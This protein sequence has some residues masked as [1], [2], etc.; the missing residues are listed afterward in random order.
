MFTN[1]VMFCQ[2]RPR[3]K[4]F[5]LLQASR[6]FSEQMKI[7]SVLSVSVCTGLWTSA[8]FAQAPADTNAATTVD[9]PAVV[10]SSKK[11]SPRAKK[12]PR[13][14]KVSAPTAAPSAASTATPQNAGDSTTKIE[15]ATGPVNGIVATR[16]ATGTKTDTPLIETSQSVSVISA[17]RMKQQGAVSVTQALGYTAGVTGAVYGVDTRFDWL[18]IRGFDAYQPGFFVDGMIARNNNTW[19]VW[20]V[21][22]YGTERI[23]VLKGPPSVLYGQANAGGM[24]NVVSKRPLEEPLNETEL[25]IGSHG[26]VEGLFDF[27]G[28][29]TN[30]G[31]VLYRLTG[32]V[33]DT[34]T[35][36]DYTDQKRVYIAPAITWRPTTST[37]LTLL[38]Q[39]LKEDDVPN[40]GFLPA[41]GV[42]QPN[43]PYGNISRSFFT[44]EP[45]YNTFQQEQWAAGYLFEHKFDD[46]WKVRQNVRYSEV[47]VNYKQVIGGGWLN[48][49]GS[50]LDRYAF[51]SLEHQESFVT[52][53]Q[54]QGDFV[55]VGI[56]HTVLA[57][58]DYQHNK[59][60]RVS[61]YGGNFP[62]NPYNPVY[63][64][65]VGEFDPYYDGKTLLQ[66]T[67]TYLQEQARYDGWVVTLG[68]R[69]DWSDLHATDKVSG[70]PPDQHDE[71]FTWR[72]GVLYR[73]ESGLAPYYSYST[74]FFPTAGHD[75]VTDKPFV[76]E[77]GVQHEVGIKYEIPGIKSLFTLAAFDIKRQNYV[78]SDLDFKSHQTGEVHSQ[79]IE[80]EGS[81]ELAPG[82]DLIAAYTWLPTFEATKSSNPDELFKRIPITPEHVASL[83]L[84]Y[85][86]QNGPLAGLGFGGGVRYT[87]ETYGNIANDADMR[88]PDF[89]LFDA[90]VD[91]EIDNWRLAVNVSNIADT[92]TF[93]CWDICYYGAGREVL[94]S[95]RHRW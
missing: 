28:P 29:A 62:I 90:V 60:D 64:A 17:D 37:S 41:K 78:T 27:S 9:L 40:I 13:K 42:Q 35:Q 8:V 52:D 49:P 73:T 72:G 67:G 48:D 7:L 89:T 44:G 95:I 31:K 50:L 30:D 21:E 47:D 94:A 45:G 36:V 53:N 77:T 58:V 59:Y 81:V 61:T 34:D 91:Y 51:T 1:L 32:V 43:P 24:V 38:G 76:P 84:H 68:G 87:G 23:E 65:T 88:V 16:S 39:Y 56:R 82:I 74:S 57:G 54:V 93:N 69:Y 26:R 46:V 10:V 14:V 19:S 6:W 66:Q 33:L 20:K 3:T 70:N 18:N 2:V 71:A 5:Q 11:E 75:D 12:K 86:L 80:F 85:K 79:G 63:G 55:A 83:W 25:R 4:S 92:T 15:N 22:P